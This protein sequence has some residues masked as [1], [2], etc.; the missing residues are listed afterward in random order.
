VT[1]VIAKLGVDSL[2]HCLCFTMPCHCGRDLR[3]VRLLST[4]KAIDLPLVVVNAELQHRI[5]EQK[6]LRITL[7]AANL[8]IR[9]MPRVTNETLL[10]A[11]DVAAALALST[12]AVYELA[13]SR[14]I[15]CF[16][17]GS[18][19]RFSPDDVEQYLASCHTPAR[20][21]RAALTLQRSPLASLIP[22][23]LGA[24]FEQL[25][26]KPKLTPPGQLK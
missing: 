5:Q 12:R 10:T 15:A 23:G 20:S 26:V 21:R 24:A 3:Y 13:A 11:A 22:S 16:R 4:D 17:F 7:G 18:A 8:T 9:G 2:G 1:D 6:L 14:K 19:I 25:G